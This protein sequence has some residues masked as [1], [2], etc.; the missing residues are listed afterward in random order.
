[1]AR[2]VGLDR[3]RVIEVAGEVADASGLDQL[4]LAQVADRLGVRLPSLYNHVAGLPGLRRDLALA[5][6]RQ[7]GERMARAAIGKASD[8]AVLAIAQ[9]Y[10][11]YVIQ[12]SGLYAAS[13]RAP[14]PDDAELSRASQAIIE[15]VLAV[16]APYGLGEESAIHAVRGLR[17]IIHGF[18]TIELGGGFG[19]A[20]DRDESFRR[21]LQSYLAGLR[22]GAY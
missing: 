8:D 5:S 7:L 3:A 18:A 19:M 15:I 12:H 9:A 14:A 21:L 2:S 4:T 6:L 11:D 16:L 10:R 17:S 22:S 20:L 13:V 1:M